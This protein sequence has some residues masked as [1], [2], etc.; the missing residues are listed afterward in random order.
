MQIQVN[1]DKCTGCRLCRQICTIYHFDEINPRKAAIRIEAQFPAPGKFKP[2]VCDQCGNCAEACPEDAI[3]KKDGVY[4]IDE[5]KCTYCLL[6]VEA[7]P[8]DVMFEHDEVGI[9]IK[10]DFC[11][12]CTEVCNTGAIVKIA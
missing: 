5:E 4:I 7:C 9:P 2:W 1:A 6:C 3:Y 11:W 8:Y 10:C 12:K